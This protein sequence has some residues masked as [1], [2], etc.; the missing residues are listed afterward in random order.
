MKKQT[1]EVLFFTLLIS[2]IILDA[3][4]DFIVGLIPAI[5][6]VL[7]SVSNAFWGI[8]QGGL[9]YGLFTAGKK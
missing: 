5:G 6:G 3:F 4:T 9:A 7:S 2:V 1:K 8:I